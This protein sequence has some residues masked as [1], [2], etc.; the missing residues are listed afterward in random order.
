MDIRELN[1]MMSGDVEDLDAFIAE[2]DERQELACTAN[3]C[4]AN[5]CGA[6]AS[7]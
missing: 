7:N 3:V 5:G 6:N 1:V 2:L 4:G